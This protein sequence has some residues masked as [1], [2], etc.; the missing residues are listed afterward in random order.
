MSVL[1]KDKYFIA[2]FYKY[3]FVGLMLEW[4]KDDMKEDPKIIVDK[5]SLM[6]QGNIKESLNRVRIDKN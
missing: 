2:N 3:G 4:I 5:L 6:I 1:K